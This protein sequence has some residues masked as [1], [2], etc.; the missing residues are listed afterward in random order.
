VAA[1]FPLAENF[2]DDDGNN[3]KERL[4]GDADPMNAGEGFVVRPHSSYT[5]GNTTYDLTYDEG[6]LNNGDITFPVVFN[7]TKN[8]SPNFLG[9]PYPS[10]ISADD[11][12]NGNAMVDELYFWEHLTP[13]S[14]GLPG[15]YAMNFSMEDLSMYNLS[16]GIAAA[17]DPSGIDTALNGFI[18]TAQGFAIKANA[19]GTATFTNAMRRLSNNNTLRRP[20]TPKNRLWLTLENDEYELQNSTLIGFFE[21]TTEGLDIGYDSRRLATTLSIFSETSTGEE[22]GIQARETFDPSIKIPVGFSSLLDIETRY[23]ISLSNIEG[24]VLPNEKVF[25]YDNMLGL[26]TELTQQPYE[27][28]A[29]KGTYKSRFTLVFEEESLAVAANT[30]EEVRLFPNPGQEKIIISAAGKQSIIGIKIYDLS[31]RMVM[32]NDYTDLG[33]LRT[34]DISRLDS[35]SYLIVVKGASGTQTLSFIK[36]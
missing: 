9:N 25:L 12:I 27:F 10:A 34:V 33:S 30:F 18:A 3:W 13:P 21:E 8:D 5:D 24:D 19:A 6:T 16:G 35:A 4:V 26:L 17:S 28:V 29:V 36:E 14:P 11:F 7:T 22:F 15:A 1:A 32:E 20:D 23:R 2:A 31:G